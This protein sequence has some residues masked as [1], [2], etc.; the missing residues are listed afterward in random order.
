VLRKGRLE[1]GR[2]Y[3][4]ADEESNAP[5]GLVEAGLEVGEMTEL[6]RD[7]LPVIAGVVGSDPATAGRDS[8][9]E[10][11]NEDVGLKGFKPANP[12]MCD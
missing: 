6:L 12:V 1:E 3:P 10:A 9:N 11:P 8:S 5:R 7:A 4:V 2:L